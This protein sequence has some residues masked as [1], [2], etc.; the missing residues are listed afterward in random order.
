VDIHW[1]PRLLKITEFFAEGRITFLQTA[2]NLLDC[3]RPSTA[4]DPFNMNIRKLLLISA[5]ILG[6]VGQAAAQTPD[7]VTVARVTG[8]VTAKLPDGSSVRHHR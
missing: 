6:L 3:R 2:C 4:H 7:Q 1:I 8:T 5:A